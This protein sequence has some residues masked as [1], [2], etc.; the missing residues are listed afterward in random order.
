MS[1]PVPPSL[2]FAAVVLISGEAPLEQPW[3][4]A[5]T[6]DGLKVEVRDV[7]GSPFEE[8]RVTAVSLH[9]LSTLCD[10]V[11]GR[12]A[13][14]EGHFKKRVVIRESDSDRWTY[15]QVRV[16]VVT[17]RDLIVHT[18]LLAPAQTGRCEVKFETGTDPGFPKINDHV[19]VGAVRGHWLLEP[20]ADAKVE[21]TYTVYSEPGGAIPAFL[22]RNG[23]RQAAVEFMKTILSRAQK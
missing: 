17:D 16:P 2:L 19:R 9:A 20:I 14:V 8:V 4:P 10:A 21:I 18:Q 11:W 7:K 23:Q 6:I 13:K 15:E 22:A 1:S 3:R 5:R 12:D